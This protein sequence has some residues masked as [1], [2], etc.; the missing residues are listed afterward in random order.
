MDA[1]PIKQPKGAPKRPTRVFSYNALESTHAFLDYL[2]RRDSEAGNSRFVKGRY[3]DEAV[4]EKVVRDIGAR[5]AARI[6]KAANRK[7]LDA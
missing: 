7:R 3:V 6:K 2:D 1:K 5:E 4:E